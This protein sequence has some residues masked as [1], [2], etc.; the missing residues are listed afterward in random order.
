[1]T[2]QEELIANMDLFEDVKKNW[3][4]NEL[5]IAYRIYNGHHGTGLIDTGCGRCRRSVISHCIHIAK[6]FKKL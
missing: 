4:G 2:W 1:M 6:E 5:A 3:T